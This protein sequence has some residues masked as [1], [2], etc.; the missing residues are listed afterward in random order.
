MRV[1][2][3]SLLLYNASAAKQWCEFDGVIQYADDV[4]CV[5]SSEWN[6]NDITFKFTASC[7]TT[8]TKTL[9]DDGEKSGDEKV[10]SFDNDKIVLKTLFLQLTNNYAK[11]KIWDG[12]RTEG[13]FVAFGCFDNQ[14]FCRTTV[15]QDKLAYIDHHWHGISLF[16]D[17]DQYFYI[18]IYWEGNELPVQLFIDGYVSQHVT[19]DY[20]KSSTQNLSYLYSRNRY[21]FTGNSNEDLIVI[22]NKD[23][24]AKEVC[25][26]FKYKRFLFFEKSYKTTYLS[27]TACTCKS[28]THQLLETYD[29]NYP[30]CRYNHSLYDL[31]LTNDVDNEVTIEVQLSS[32]YSVLFDTNK[33]YILTPFND[34]TTPM[35]FTHFEMKENVKVEFLIEV[36]IN[37]LTITSIGDYYF[38]KGVNIQTVNN[39]KD[40][41]NKILFSVDKKLTGDGT[42]L[43]CGRRVF[44]VESLL[45]GYMCYCNYT[46]GVWDPSD[47]SLNKGDCLEYS[48]QSSLILQ[49]DSANYDVAAYQS[50]QQINFFNQRSTITGSHVLETQNANIQSDVVFQN[51]NTVFHIKNMLEFNQ[52]THIIFQ[53]FTTLLIDEDVKTVLH[54]PQNNTNRNGIIMIETDANFQNNNDAMTVQFDSTTSLN[55]CIEL[56]SFESLHQFEAFTPNSKLIGGKL[57][58]ICHEGNLLNENTQCNFTGNDMNAH[59]SYEENILHCPINTENAMI[60]LKTNNLAQTVNF[61]G[62]FEQQN[63]STL[64]FTKS[65]NHLTQFKEVNES[66][67]Y[68]EDNS[69]DGGVFTLED[70]T[71]K[72]F[73]GNNFGFQSSTTKSMKKS[74]SFAVTSDTKYNCVGFEGNVDSTQNSMCL[75]CKN[76]CYLYENK[77]NVISTVCNRI[78]KSL[79][80]SLCEECP[81]KYEAKRYECY[82]CPDKCLRCVDGKCISCEQNYYYDDNGVCLPIDN[83]TGSV[84]LYWLQIARKCSEGYYTSSTTCLK[85]PDNCIQCKDSL[86][87]QICNT[88]SFLIN[89]GD[90]VICE[91]QS[92]VSLATTS[93]ILY[94][95]TSYYKDTSSNSC[96][97][98]STTFGELCDLCDFD[99]CLKCS[100]NGIINRVTGQCEVLS[101]T[102]CST[103][104][105]T[106]C[107]FCEH[108]NYTVNT[109]GLC[110]ANTNCAISFK[111]GKCPVCED[112]YFNT[113]SRVCELNTTQSDKCTKL[114]QEGDRCYQCQTGYFVKDNK[115]SKCSDNCVDCYNLDECL[116]CKDNY[117]LLENGTCGEISEVTNNCK[118]L[119][120]T[121]SICA[122]CHTNYFRDADGKCE[123]CIE[124]CT[125]CNQ[126]STCLQCVQY[127]FLLT[128]STKC[129]SYD[130]LDNCDIKTMSGCALCS[131]GYFI[132]NQMCAKCDS[133]TTNCTECTQYGVCTSCT[134]NFVLLSDVC[135][136]IDKISDCIEIAQ[137]KCSKCTFWH[138]PNNSGTSCQTQ[139]VWWVIFVC[140]FFV[141]IVILLFIIMCIIIT[142]KVIEHKRRKKAQKETCLF[143]MSKSN[144]KFIKTTNKNVVV[145]TNK[146]TF[147][148]ADCGDLKVGEELRELICIGNNSKNT[149]KV[150]FSSK[151]DNYKYSFRSEPKVVSIPKGKACEFE[152]FLLVNCSTQIEDTISLFSANLKKGETSEVSI[153]IS[154]KTEISTRLDPD[155]LKEEKKLGEGSFG[156]VYKGIFRGHVVAIKKMK[157]F[158]ETKQSMDEFTKEVSMLDKF[159]SEYIV[160][161]YGAVFIPSKICMVT[162]FAEFGSLRDLMDHKTTE[163]VNL[164]VKTKICLD[165]S[166]GILYLHENGILHRDIKPDNFL[167]FSLEAKDTVNAKLTDFG[168]SRNVNQL[169]SNMTFTKGIGTPKYMAPEVLG[170]EKYKKGADV[171]SFAITMY[172]CLIWANPFPKDKFKYPWSIADFITSGKRFDKPE[173]IPN[174]LYDILSRAW[175]CNVDERSDIE[176]VVKSLE[177]AISLD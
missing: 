143:E 135:T 75:S 62:H 73:M 109:S 108:K 9:N 77:C 118:K 45:N 48:L 41:T 115:C 30:D 138:I 111:N 104:Q 35:T 53:Q 148:S 32:Y 59:L 6:I 110:E 171:F 140:V 81:I 162:E 94:C 84:Q 105:N 10:F 8:Q 136:S 11:I 160:H 91:V 99:K 38:K 141:L 44:Y 5:E 97:R 47:T 158:S 27:Y 1:I 28:T 161:F 2:L 12:N 74:L 144:I 92:N 49:I 79:H 78:Y 133:K 17:I 121:R 176:T 52:N 154:G 167:I 89:K 18:W 24:V 98:C 85:C 13:L 165:S 82:Q 149:I 23:G 177:Q 122:I 166:K 33:K 103:T 88:I 123:S 22:K 156:I 68:I 119:I 39:N 128:D 137:S 93:T 147:E 152:V 58:R 34:K 113:P 112:G 40:F 63:N 106:Y 142:F 65:I 36:F 57:Y 134:D 130:Y 14:S 86:T 172:E 146:I 90:S 76:E 131:K 168:S 87:C 20:M 150:Q 21:L 72:L 102:S 164:T 155:E 125:T 114:T 25:E 3:L 56:I 96:K 70:Q 107:T 51:I 16:S 60:L 116:L 117:F 71:K 67:I 157:E 175:T 69:I 80:Y 19:L 151:G 95:A 31:D 54:N 101:E 174:V 64:K 61:N 139:A 26:R 4:N 7:C 50:W 15:R 66:V 100:Q 173:E 126:K 43:S 159:R 37:N 129:L 153:G 170:K 132:V 163:E 127:N 29:W 83:S 55:Y 42:L 169:V 145:N 46:N 120:Q 124:N